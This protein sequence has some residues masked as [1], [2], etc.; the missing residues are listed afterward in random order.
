MASA[1]L[2]VKLWGDY[3]CFTRPETKTERVSYP[4]MTPSAARGALEAIFW[5][6]Q[7]D[8]IVK[9]IHMLKPVRYVSIMRNEI[10]DRQSLRTAKQW[11]KKGG[12]YDASARRTQRHSLL[13]RDVAY[14]VRGDIALRPGVGDH[15]A[16][17]RDQ[18]RRR[19]DRGR[20]FSTP[21]LGCRE[22][23]ASFAP[24]AATDRP[25]P[26]DMDLGLMLLDI[27]YRPDGTGQG[28]P[29]F[30]D[31]QVTQGILRVPDRL[32]KSTVA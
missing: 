30:F 21:F 23:S 27:D 14:I 26:V 17:Y 7:M 28:T 11:A 13:L 8:W 1:L 10:K 4:T 3:A 29:K 18:F 32:T 19:V 20:C 5:K 24:P 16:K 6:P 31:A 22:F 2:E 12:G 9:E 15:V 25:L